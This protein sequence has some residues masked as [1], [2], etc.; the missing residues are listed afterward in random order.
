MKPRIL[1]SA[2]LA[3]SALMPASAL[4]CACGCG[5][6]G[7]GTSSLFPTGSGGQAWVDY[8]YLNQDQNRSGTHRSDPGDNED[9]LVRTNAVTL[10]G[11]YMLDRS[12]GLSNEIPLWDRTFIS[13]EDAADFGLKRHDSGIADIRLMGMYTGFSPDLSTGIKFGVKLP[14]GGFHTP[15]FDRDTSIG[16]G[17]TDLLLGAFHQG[18]LNKANTLSYFVQASWDRPI[19]Y[20]EGYKPGQ[21]F[22]AAAGLVHTGFSAG[23]VKVSPVLQVIAV[24]RD[25]DRGPESNPG[26]TGYDRILASP[27][28]EV[29]AGD[30]KFYADVGLPLY[31]RYRGQQLAAPALFKAIVSRAF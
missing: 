9:K 27:G 18:N 7:V 6:F 22:D 10:G 13:E 30:W 17:S 12:W 1:L 24:H 14:T 25:H 4:A 31:E 26:D 11:Q 21:E 19:A 20:Q 5:V 16:S 2:L 8:D 29:A 23:K 28:V 15:G 3:A